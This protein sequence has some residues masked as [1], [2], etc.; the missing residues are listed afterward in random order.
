MALHR[1]V[2]IAK[3]CARGVSILKICLTIH[4]SPWSRFKGGGQIAVHQ[5][6]CALSRKGC[7]VHVVYSKHPDENPRPSVPY[8]LHWVRRFD[9]ATVNLDIFSFAKKLRR[10]LRRQRFDIV[11]GNAEEFFFIP[12][13][14]RKWGVVPFF[15]S[16]APFLPQQGA[17]RGLLKPVW[18]LKRVNPHLLRAA[19]GRSHTVVTFS[20]FSKQLV[21]DAFTGTHCP[22]LETVDP[23]V[24]PSWFDVTRCPDAKA[25]LLFWGRVEEE[26]GLLELFEALK[27]V[28]R[29]RSDVRLTL[30]GEGNRL[31]E[32]RR[33]ASACNLA[34]EF[35]GWQDTGKIQ[36]L[37]ARAWA[38]VFPSR[39]ESFGLAV[40]EAQAVGL[41]VI[42]TRAGALP[43]IVQDGSTGV[44]VPPK[45][46]AA[47]ARALI[48]FFEDRP[49]FEAMAEK[50]RELA[51]SRFSWEKTAD[52]LLALYR[53]ALHKKPG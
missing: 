51:K 1:V 28:M 43:E 4:S 42:A 13:L 35:L 52:R 49:R 2:R 40:A 32:Y 17:L 36:Q 46:A 25:N 50:G 30:V 20:E 29:M 38:G 23:G 47:L 37:A 24:D 31:E 3:R 21:A 7:E 5:M 41:P 44:L 15:T 26:K 8:T 33:R 45:D 53:A 19:A 11:H 48:E 10:L 9:C 27:Q 34:V 22:R 18:L 16:H 6:A 14:C 12:G 39:I